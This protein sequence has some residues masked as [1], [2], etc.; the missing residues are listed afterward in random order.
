MPHWLS[1]LIVIGATF[2]WGTSFPLSQ[3]V[4]RGDIGVTAMLALRFGLGALTILSLVLLLRIRTNG[5][6]AGHGMI[7]GVIVTAG[8]W[9]QMDGLRYTS[10]PKSGF[11]TGL[12]VLFTP[13]CALLFGEK[14]KLHHGAAAALSVVGLYGLVYGGDGP[15][16]PGG[17]N[18][19]DLETL[20]A[21]ALFGL[22]IYLIGRFSRQTHGM[23]LALGQVGTVAVLCWATI[24]LGFGG[25]VS[26]ITGMPTSAFLVLIYLGFM[27]TGIVICGQ[28]LVQ[29]SL[30]PTEAAILFTLEPLFAALLAV[31]GVVPGVHDHLASLQWAGAGLL[32]AAPILTEQGDA[33]FRRGARVWRAN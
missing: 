23:I 27:A 12:F 5:R 15:E 7:L 26:A 30:G 28:C 14:V 16:G 1:I 22:Q 32:L 11:I 21:A 25:P 24:L 2:V 6:G 3:Y 31:A 8:F 17:W 20:I 33:L 9:L 29:A 10:V 4:L 13:I 19:G 18:L